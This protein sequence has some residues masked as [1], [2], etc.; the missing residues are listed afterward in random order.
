MTYEEITQVLLTRADTFKAMGATG[1]YMF[2]SRAR[3]DN[4][5]DSDLD[6]F[7]DHEE[8]KIRPSLFD[9]VAAE[10]DIGDALGIPVQ[11]AIREGLFPEIRKRA[12]GEAAKVF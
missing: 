4:R 12:E 11:L 7:I 10:N 1:L 9:I 3:G 5:P 8:R 2:V 6:L